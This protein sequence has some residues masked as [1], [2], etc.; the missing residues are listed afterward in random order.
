MKIFLIV[1]V[2]LLLSTLCFAQA[3]TVERVIDGD[4]LKLTN[5]ETVRLIGIDCPEID[6]EEGKKA[7]ELVKRILTLYKDWNIVLEFDVEKRD[8]YGRQLAYVFIDTEIKEGEEF[9]FKHHSD[10]HFDYYDGKWMCFL[11]ATIIK[12][13]YASP[14]TISPNVRH[15]DLFQRLYKEARENKRGLWR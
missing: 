12:V 10:Y 5:G 11:N 14:M 6:T 3:Y 13:G 15:A 1:L 4:I 8:K 2:L 9:G 7:T